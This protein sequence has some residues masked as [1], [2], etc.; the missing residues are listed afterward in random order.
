MGHK[1]KISTND[2]EKPIKRRKRR[3]FS[4]TEVE[5]LK[6]GVRRFGNRWA[7]IAG[8]YAFN[9]RTNIDLSDKWRNMTRS[10]KKSSLTT[11]KDSKTSKRP[12]FTHQECVDIVKGVE[13]FGRNWK[14][15]LNEFN[16]LPERLPKHLAEKW[17]NMCDSVT[18]TMNRESKNP[19]YMN[20]KSEISES[21]NPESNISE[22]VNSNAENRT[23][24][25]SKSES[26]TLSSTCAQSDILK[27]Y[28]VLPVS[29]SS[30]A[31]SELPVA[32]KAVN[33]CRA[34]EIAAR[35]GFNYIRLVELG[36]SN[37]Y[38]YVVREKNSAENPK[39]T[40]LGI[41]KLLG[42]EKR[43]VGYFMDTVL[44]GTLDM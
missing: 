25:S 22:S 42:V 2:D 29:K 11:Q 15:I 20:P 17:R 33:M 35:R 43:M 13:K 12:P 36:S 23:S 39:T 4:I 38:S 19:E 34:A 37:V 16:F 10:R 21:G 30:V 9:N 24:N 41:D 1:R 28:L 6:M 26:I 8:S 14:A 44:H 31:P 7:I 40:I 3:P 5:N 18:R 32:V 27:Y